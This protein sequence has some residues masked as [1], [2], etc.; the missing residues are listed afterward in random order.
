ML[1]LSDFSSTIAH[2]RVE[3]ILLVGGRASQE[4]RVPGSIPSLWEKQLWHFECRTRGVHEIGA[5]AHRH[6][7]VQRPRQSVA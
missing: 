7:I 2:D 4:T 3:P 5:D 6:P 1:L